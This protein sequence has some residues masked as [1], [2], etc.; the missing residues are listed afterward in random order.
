MRLQMLN[1]WAIGDPPGCVDPHLPMNSSPLEHL[2]PSLVPCNH[3]PMG[4]LSANQ[5]GLLC[6]AMRHDNCGRNA[7]CQKA[8][9]F[10]S[11]ENTRLRLMPGMECATARCAQVH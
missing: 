5:P 4:P 10:A 2:L 1:P 8:A 7:A 11:A 6:P 3:A 9:S